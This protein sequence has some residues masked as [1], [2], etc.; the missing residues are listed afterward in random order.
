MSFKNRRLSPPSH[1]FSYSTVE[2]YY[3]PT[4]TYAN[5]TLPE[6]KP[7]PPEHNYRTSCFTN[8]SV[9]SASLK[10]VFGNKG[11]NA[12]IKPFYEQC[13]SIRKVG[14]EPRLGTQRGDLLRHSMDTGR[15]LAPST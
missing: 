6:I 1:N 11:C 13:H 10:Q 8:M 9:R 5:L 4:Y 7:Y 14:L 3:C 12:D 2:D 15:L